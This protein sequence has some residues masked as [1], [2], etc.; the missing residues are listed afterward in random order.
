M[1][2]LL[3]GLLAS[4]A[5]G[6]RYW[7]HAPQGTMPPYV[8]M[9]RITGIRDYHMRGASG[10]VE[11]RVQIDCYAST[12]AGAKSTA[13]SVNGILSGYR[14]GAIQAIFIDNERDLPTSD[15]GEVNQ[16]FRTSLDI[17][18]HHKEI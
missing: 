10:L 1:E 11:S 9:Q 12:Y 14:G 16:L 3:T 13:K 2:A 6:N 8:V 4:V 18:V 5:G 17:M 15:A 7:L